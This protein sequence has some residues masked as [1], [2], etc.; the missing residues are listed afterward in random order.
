[1]KFSRFTL[2]VLAAY[3]LCSWAALVAAYGQEAEE[4][5]EAVELRPVDYVNAEY[6][7]GL[8]LPE[9]YTTF[10]YEEGDVWVLQ[11]IG[12]MEQPGA[13]ISVEELP[14]GVVDVAGYWQLLKE[15]DPMMA[16]NITYEKVGAVAGTGAV[17]SRVEYFEADQYILVITWAF[18]HAGHGFTIS[19]YPPEMGEYFLAKDIALDVAQQFRWMSDEEIASFEAA[20]VDNGGE[21][22]AGESF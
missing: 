5:G 18:V 1:M 20:D 3:I 14:E 22:P 8:A 13:R 12:E 4:E 16:R 21:I 9:G 19:G 17:L 7:F 2:L 15:R 6:E 10:E 11:M